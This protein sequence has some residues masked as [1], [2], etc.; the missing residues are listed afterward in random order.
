[1][2]FH[3]NN[4]TFANK[5]NESVIEKTFHSNLFEEGKSTFI[6]TPLSYA[7]ISQLMDDYLTQT[8]MTI[9]PGVLHNNSHSW[10]P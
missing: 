4:D 2:R 5:I 9:Q 1:M 6:V 8:L 3:C 10:P 7:A